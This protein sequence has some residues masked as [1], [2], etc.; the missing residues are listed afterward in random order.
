MGCVVHNQKGPR[1]TNG[2]VSDWA[3][4]LAVRGAR[5]RPIPIGLCTVSIL[6]RV[7]SG[8]ASA[9]QMGSL[10]VVYWRTEGCVEY[11]SSHG[12]CF[13]SEVTL[14]AIGACCGWRTKEIVVIIR[15][16]RWWQT[17]RGDRQAALA[18]SKAGRPVPGRVGQWPYRNKQNVRSGYTRFYGIRLSERSFGTTSSGV[19][20]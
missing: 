13:S 15:G 7:E 17:H 10:I 11:E 6:S 18:S 9:Y 8:L 14:A 16:G 3:I 2:Q 19:G 5:S 4:V 12:I 1:R 20:E